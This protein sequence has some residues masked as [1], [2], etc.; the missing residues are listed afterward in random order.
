MGPLQQNILKNLVQ[1]FSTGMLIAFLDLPPNIC[2]LQEC[3]SII[4]SSVWFSYDTRI[5]VQQIKLTR[6]NVL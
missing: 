5:Y 2:M 1:F 3:Q 6:F 4:F